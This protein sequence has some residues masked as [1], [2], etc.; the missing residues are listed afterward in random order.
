MLIKGMQPPIRI[1]DF[2]G[3]RLAS[4][5]TVVALES[6]VISHGLPR[7]TNLETAIEC[8]DIITAEGATPATVGVVSGVPTIGLSR[9]E[10]QVFAEG[11]GPHGTAIEKVSLNNLGIVVSQRKWGATTVAGSI[12]IA[13]LG[14]QAFDAARR[15]LVFSTGGIGGVHR[16]A[17]ATQD[18]SADLTA[19]AQAQIVCVCAGAKAILDLARTREALETFG[20]PVIGFQTD[21]FPAFYSLRSGLGV[22]ASVDSA[23]QAAQVAL[24]H[25]RCGGHGAVLLCVPVPAE[26]EVPA[27]ELEAVIDAAL[28]T[29]DRQGVRGKAVTPFL[30]AEMAKA[31]GGKTLRANRALLVNNASVA[32]RVAVEMAKLMK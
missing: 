18:I 4:S 24:A 7:P 5:G 8:E 9:E 29:A 1:S 2:V 23:E 26:V 16:G 10:L 14:A 25:W 20:V 17:E 6:T 22:D 32:A 28:V 30:L 11:W 13:T 21:E 12:W 19:L 15:P 3:D 31:S 27:S